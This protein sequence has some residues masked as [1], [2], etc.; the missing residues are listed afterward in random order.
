MIDIQTSAPGKVIVAGEYAVLDGA[1]AICMAVDR[2]AHVAI[3]S[4]EGDWHSVLAPG[5]VQTAGRFTAHDGRVHW[6]A[7]AADFDLLTAVW[8]ELAARPV[9]KLAI[10]LDS[11]EF[12][13]TA[14]GIK[15][16][17]G[18]SAALTVA[19]TAALDLAAG[20]GASVYRVA[21][22]AHR[23][24]QSGAGSGADIACSLSG[25]VI[26]FRMGEGPQR[27]LHWP[28]GL[29]YALLWSGVSSNTVARLARLAAATAG[30]TRTE[31]ATAAGAVA[32]TWHG[33]QA[34]DISAALRDYAATLRRFDAEHGLGIYAAGHAA[35]ADAGESCGVVYKPCGAGGGDLGIAI[36]T[37][38]AALAG[39][40]A[41]AQQQAFRHLPMAIEVRGLRND[42]ELL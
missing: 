42:G 30:A 14:T 27:A 25:G 13:D 15:L 23:Q 36:A 37:D 41:L 9:G 18:S 16:G 11:N 20:G 26:E 4:S 24:L 1:P 7:G 32:T 12:V 21:A 17:I 39:F 10:V 33:G 40:V 35:L 29:H 3:T 31:L 22:G 8:H 2:R 34:A 38:S 6:Q 28:A 5:H 19:L